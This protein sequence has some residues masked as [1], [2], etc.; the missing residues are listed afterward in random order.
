MHVHLVH[1][2]CT[3]LFTSSTNVTFIHFVIQYNVELHVHCSTLDHRMNFMNMYY[4]AI[5]PTLLSPLASDNRCLVD[6]FD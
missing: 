1:L 4:L 5:Y 2:I 6:L 3:G